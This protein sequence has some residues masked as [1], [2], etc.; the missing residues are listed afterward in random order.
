MAKPNIQFREATRTASKA[1]I[2]IEGLSGKGKSGLALAIAK[3]LTGDWS[4]VYGSDTENKSLDLFD[5]LRMHTGAESFGKFKKFDLLPT[6]GY[7]PTN[8]LAAIEAAKA[9]GAEAFINDSITHMWQQKGGLLELVSDIQ[10]SDTKYNKW[11]VW[12]HPTVMQEKNAIYPCIRDSEIHMI[13]TVRVKEKFELV[14]GKMQSL[15]EQQQMMP[16]LKFEPDLVIHM[17]RPGNEDGTPPRG[18]IVKS[19]YAILKE[20][21]EYDFTESLLDQLRAYLSEG[22]DPKILQEAQRV[23]FIAELKAQ[24]AHNPGLNSMLP[25]LA[26]QV[27]VKDKELDT[28]TLGE[29]RKLLTLI[30]S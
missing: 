21:T 12:G 3:A 16:D 4:T 30:L 23:E 14:E 8:Y 7:A 17:L 24:I 26:E 25:L 5:G 27:G 28:L 6:H 2:V 29:A 15:G 13:S 9:A 20:N 18:R 1:C 10:R 22:A 11:T 19:R